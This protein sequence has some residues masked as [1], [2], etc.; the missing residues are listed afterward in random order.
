MLTQKDRNS[1]YN[2]WV[3]VL[4]GGKDGPAYGSS[5]MN[6]KSV[7]ING[8]YFIRSVDVRGSTFAVQADFNK[9]T[10]LE[11]IGAPKK[12]TKLTINGQAFNYTTSKLGNWIA[13][14]SMTVPNLNLPSLHDLDWHGID[15]VPELNSDYD[16]SKWQPANQNTT[17]NPMANPLLT[18][19]SLYGSDYGFNT[20]TLVF[21]GY[22]V[23]SG[24]E[25]SLQ[26]RTQGGLAFGSS[27]WVGNTFLGSV[28]GNPDNDDANS[29][30]PIRPLVKGHTYVLTV[31]VDNMGYN[32]N[33]NP[34]YDSMKQPRGIVSYG[35]TDSEGNETKVSKWKLTGNLGG[36]SYTDRFRGPLNEGGLF[37]ERQGYHLPSPPLNKFN[38]S[39][40]FDGL[41]KPGVKFYAAK[42]PLHL[43]S[44]KYDIPLSFTIDNSTSTD[45][46]AM[47]YINGFQFGKYVSYLGP[48]TE[49]PVPEGILNYNGD[50]WIGL[51]VW[52]QDSD[53]AK[54]PKLTLNTRGAIQT[55]RNKINF[56]RGTSYRKRDSY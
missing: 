22:F 12:T 51:A 2:Y 55:S 3:P 23:S 40:P 54:V 33:L 49:F 26:I 27:A 17:N 16:D 41:S 4:A 9:T 43:P 28:K 8:G 13:R 29:T 48:Q 1:A 25:S 37:F 18:P 20:G 31:L 36:E 45:Y 19:V 11:I 32:E 35:L 7:I 5:A 42:F 47:L 53:G 56:I 15:S 34:G 38:K 30:Y 24:K 44:P 21:R 50:N 6:P 52:A 14:P 10:T 39:S 46:R